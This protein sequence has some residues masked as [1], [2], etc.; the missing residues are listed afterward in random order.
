MRRIFYFNIT[1][2]CNSNC[3]FCYSHNTR[4]NSM[5]HNEITVEAFIDYIEKNHISSYDRVI[6]NGGEPLLHT[7]I[8][9]L[10]ECL[11][12]Y[13]CEILIYTN[14][15]LLSEIN[16]SKLN[17]NFRFI[18]PV[19]GYEELHDSITGVKGSYLETINGMH[20]FKENTDCLLDLKVILNNGMI[21]SDD[22][23]NRTLESLNDIYFNNAVHLT[24]MADTIISSKNNCSSISNDTA[25]CYM[26]KIFNYFLDRSCQIK[27]FDTCVKNFLWLK[28]YDLIE[29]KDNISVYF[30]DCNQERQILLE[31]PRLDCMS[32]CENKEYCISAVSE[33]T[34]LEF[35]NNKL[36]E[37]LE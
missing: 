6:I 7:R 8:Q 14:G 18:V 3:I 35:N 27:L 20:R 2:G 26:E 28:N 34:V 12:I 19:H 5:P 31:K 21:K 16:L 29:M 24:K 36:Y 23:L 15:R 1:Y 9:E 32:T 37:N 30:K 22:A 13:G 25:C 33:Y 11:K 4:H 10:L 17:S